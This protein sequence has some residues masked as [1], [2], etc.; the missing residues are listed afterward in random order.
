MRLGPNEDADKVMLQFLKAG[1]GVQEHSDNPKK[2][3]NFTTDMSLR[4]TSPTKI[5][6][7]AK[8]SKFSNLRTSNGEVFG[9]T[10]VY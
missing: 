10:Q 2:K 4:T 6:A 5:D 3:S 7:D 9:N 1:Y 8:T